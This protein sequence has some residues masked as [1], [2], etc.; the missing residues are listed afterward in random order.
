MGTIGYV[1]IS[2]NCDVGH[3]VK[4]LNGDIELNI[5]R[6]IHGGCIVWVFEGVNFLRRE[7][8]VGECFNGEQGR[9]SSVGIDGVGILDW[10]AIAVVQVQQIHRVDYLRHIQILVVVG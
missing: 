8:N 1:H 2:L 3:G 9:A 5:L 7:C 6:C 4:I 10:Y